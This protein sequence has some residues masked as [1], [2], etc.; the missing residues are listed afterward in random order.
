V[1][2]EAAS[3]HFNVQRRVWP[4][5][6]IQRREGKRER[7]REEERERKE[8]EGC[9]AWKSQGGNF[10]AASEELLSPC[11]SV[12]SQKGRQQLLF[13]VQTRPPDTPPVR[14]DICNTYNIF[15]A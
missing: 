6:E 7:R 10:T 1:K 9:M 3:S 13:K 11:S 2:S 4:N 15:I 12:G 14:V 8:G 5:R